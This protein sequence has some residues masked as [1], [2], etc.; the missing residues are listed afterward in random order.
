MPLEKD[1]AQ[2]KTDLAEIPR[3]A[4]IERL[5]S[6][7]RF[8]SKV[9]HELN[10]PLDGILRYI[11]LSLRSIEQ[12]NIEKPN[13]YLTQCRDG[14]MRMIRIV[15]E[16]LEFSRSHYTSSEEPV[17]IEQVVDEA[18]N[19]IATRIDSAN[20]K[21]TRSFA[22]DLPKLHGANLFQVFCNLI[23]NALDAMPN[24]GELSISTRAESDNYIAVEFC[25]TG[26][27]FDPKN[28]NLL[29]EP[30]FTTRQHKG[31]GL[32]LAICKDLVERCQ[33]RITA[34]N[35]PSGGSIFTVHLPAA[36]PHS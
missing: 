31:T 16:L 36:P 23:S 27:G 8:T 14:V 29:F 26:C 9:A 18:V 4:D 7:G 35:S 25:D 30:F 13:E 20:V 34:K 11:N 19:A 12:G 24:G 2:V 10:N 28:S 17:P 1:H 21:V 22:P 33:G 32:G 5:A 15:S 6:I 3:Q